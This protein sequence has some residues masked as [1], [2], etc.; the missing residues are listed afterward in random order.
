MGFIEINENEIDREK[1]PEDLGFRQK[2]IKKTN[3]TSNMIC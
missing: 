2:E 3:K 1:P